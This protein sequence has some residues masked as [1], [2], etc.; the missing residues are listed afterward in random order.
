VNQNGTDNLMD[1]NGIITELRCMEERITD[2]ILVLEVFQPGAIE[3]QPGSDS[4]AGV[5]NQRA[6][7]SATLAPAIRNKSRCR[8]V[9]Q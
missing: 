7:T 6:Q 3:P 4:F 8:R 1:L 2:I 9:R 5:Q